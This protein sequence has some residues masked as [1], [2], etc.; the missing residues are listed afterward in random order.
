MTPIP[1]SIKAVFCGVVCPLYEHR[2][3]KITRT[4]YSIIQYHN[5]QRINMFFDTTST[6]M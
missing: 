1:Y 4:P 3:E 2:M 6:K 5:Y